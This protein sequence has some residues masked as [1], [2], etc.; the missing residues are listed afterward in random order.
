MTLAVH[1]AVRDCHAWPRRHSAGYVSDVAARQAA[2][3]P[4][5]GGSAPVWRFSPTSW[6]DALIETR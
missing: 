3:L 2:A 4:G 6:R 1:S 5:P